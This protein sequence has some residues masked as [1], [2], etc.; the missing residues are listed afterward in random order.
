MTTINTNANTATNN[1]EAASRVT[2]KSALEAGDHKAL[3]II[4]A[5]IG[6][7]KD[8]VSK[9]GMTFSLAVKDAKE[10]LKENA[11]AAAQAAE[12]AAQR[13]E[14]KKADR[15]AEIAKRDEEIKV[16]KENMLKFL[17]DTVNGMGLDLE[18]AEAAATAA[19]AKK[20]GDVNKEP[21]YTFTRI[22]VTVDGKQYN[23]PTSGNMVQVLKDA[24]T[25]GGYTT[26]KD[27][28]LA[29]AV[30]KEAA[31]AAFAE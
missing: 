5:K 18:A 25:A 19:I 4:L 30:D 31:A 11:K 6:G 15:L 14:A 2:L 12:E 1:A 28:I 23:M 27:F 26:H 29:H 8:G 9:L 13:R 20:Y 17:M 7:D 10:V 22:P 24:M 21:K 3:A 16:E